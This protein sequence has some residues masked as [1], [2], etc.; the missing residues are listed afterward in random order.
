MKTLC[1]C[2]A[3]LVSLTSAARADWAY[4][5]RIDPFTDALDQFARGIPEGETVEAQGP[6]VELGCLGAAEGVPLG[7]T[8]DWG[9][10]IRNEA[11]AGDRPMASVLVRFGTA[12]PILLRMALSE[13]GTRTLPIDPRFGVP[14][15]ASPGADKQTPL[16]DPRDLHWPLYGV[17]G[18]L[19]LRTQSAGGEEI[20]LVI[21]MTGFAEATAPFRDQCRPAS[22]RTDTTAEAQCFSEATGLRPRFVQLGTSRVQFVDVRG[23]VLTYKIENPDGTTFFTSTQSGAFVLS[24]SRP[25]GR[26]VFT[27]TEPPPSLADMAKGEVFV[28]EATLNDDRQ[29]RHKVRV[30]VVGEETLTVEGCPYRTLIVEQRMEMD[31]QLQNVGRRWIDPWTL[32]VLKVDLTL[33]VPDGTTRKLES[34]ATKLE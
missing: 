9:R 10:P 31:G 21:P 33:H 7:L 13:D 24:V 5:E 14:V 19:A 15:A 4:S 18:N 30:Q 3:M 26:T 20:T 1:L 17:D 27:Y 12:K 29:T 34:L 23:E 2:L 22:V 6:H 8:I 11:A 16:V 25:D 32:A 28:R